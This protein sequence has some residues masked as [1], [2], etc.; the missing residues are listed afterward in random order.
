[1][2]DA[3]ATECPE[4]FDVQESTCVVR[5]EAEQL[6]FLLPLAEKILKAADACPTTVIKYETGEVGALEAAPGAAP[7]AE[8]PQP[9]EQKPATKPATK[10]A[11][12]KP[13]A[14]KVAVEK[15]AAEKAPAKPAK[16]P[17]PPRRK[18]VRK[19]PGELPDPRLQAFAD[20]SRL[21]AAFD[22]TETARA[23]AVMAVAGV[24]GDAPPDFRATL[25]AVGGAYTRQPT[26]EQQIRVSKGRILWRKLLGRKV[27][28]KPSAS[29]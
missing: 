9:P 28:A 20:N 4:V 11:E 18:I 15:P 22:S 7:K 14:T 1:M 17:P 21:A 8:P 19:E 24:G 23:A 2:C 27:S 25:L 12:D 16:A 10:A 3:C 6:Q 26:I 29:N 13:A 5:P